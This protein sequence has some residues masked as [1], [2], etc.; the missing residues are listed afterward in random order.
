MGTV[1]SSICGCITSAPEPDW[2]SWECP[3]C[4]HCSDDEHMLAYDDA[5]WNWQVSWE[6]R[7]GEHA[8]QC[9]RAR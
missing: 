2:A 7:A 6:R 5:C 1:Y 8:A 4:P 3:D 9:P